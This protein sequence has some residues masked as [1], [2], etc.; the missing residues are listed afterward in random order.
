MYEICSHD[1]LC[2][3]ACQDEVEAFEDAI[4]ANPLVGKLI[5]GLGGMRKF[6]FAYGNKGKRGGGRTIYYYA[7]G[8]D[9]AFMIAAYAKSKKTDLTP[10]EKKE[11]AKLAKEL[12]RH[13]KKSGEI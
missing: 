11:I 10:A 7:A 6:R 1:T 12:A 9:T 2:Q 8:P 13:S 4:A 5:P 3:S